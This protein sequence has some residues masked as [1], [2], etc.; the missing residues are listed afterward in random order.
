MIPLVAG[1]TIICGLERLSLRIALALIQLDED[2]IIVA[3]SP[4]P[5]RLGEAT[6]A[7]ATYVKGRGAH[8]PT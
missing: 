2:V 6:V 5:D 7:G 8:P 1:T 3:E 4:N